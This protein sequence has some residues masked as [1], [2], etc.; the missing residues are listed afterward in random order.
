MKAVWL[1][2]AGLFANAAMAAPPTHCGSKERAYFSCTVVGS[3]KVASL[4]G[5]PNAHE[6]TWFQYRFG[7]LQRP[8][9]VYPKQKEGSSEKFFAHFE[10]HPE[11]RFREIWFSVGE[12]EYLVASENSVENG[13]KENNHIVVYRDSKP[14]ANLK[15]G[16]A[17][18]ND[19][20]LIRS[21]IQDANE[22]GFF[23]AR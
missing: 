4:C 18:T 23:K 13:E 1:F 19:L 20:D 6:G 17:V 22:D 9:M 14:I 12:Y 3:K 16:G 10:R 5:K 2:V 8:E 15:S 7:V 11:G 21:R